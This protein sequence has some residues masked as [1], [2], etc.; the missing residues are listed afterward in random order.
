MSEGVGEARHRSSALFGNEKMVEMVLA[1]DGHLPTTAQWL[2]TRTGVAHNLC[3]AVLQRLAAAHVLKPLPRLGSRSAAF[4]DVADDDSA[5][6]AL[7]GLC[8][9]VGRLGD[10][11]P[12]PAVAVVA[13]KRQV[14]AAPSRT[15][16]GRV[17][18]SIGESSP[19]S[20]ASAS[21]VD[22]EET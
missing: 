8:N 18:G 7:V 13:A 1:M 5:W 15:P 9:R 19:P 20:R 16:Q 11:Q 12:E 6:I 3:R 2:A 10:D 14:D 4:Y 22:T 17:A 21:R